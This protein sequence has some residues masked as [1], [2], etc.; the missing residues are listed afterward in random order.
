[1]LQNSTNTFLL[2]NVDLSFIRFIQKTP[3]TMLFHPFRLFSLMWATTFL[4]ACNSLGQH[5]EEGGILENVSNDVFAK[6]IQENV[7]IL[8]VRT[9]EETELGIIE[10]ATL[11]NLY[12]DGFEEKIQLMEKSKPILVYCASGGRSG[13]AATILAEQGFLEV[14]NL[15]GGMY[16]W[17][18][19]GFP[20]SKALND[21]GS[22]EITRNELLT[23]IQEHDVVLIDFYAP[24]CAPCKAMAPVID[25]I[26]KSYANSIRIE[27]VD[28]AANPSLG[29]AFDVASIPVFAIYHMGK[30]VWRNNGLTEKSILVDEIQKTL[31]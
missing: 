27:R 5:P 11:I 4:F 6:K 26:E 13:Q 24:W 9:P 3:W 31:D 16:A 1:M 28:V 8:D 21:L 29:K 10:G 12:E 7:L 14:Y 18:N 30:E 23:I 2:V 19:A 15:E 25:D 22:S 20:V 17:Q